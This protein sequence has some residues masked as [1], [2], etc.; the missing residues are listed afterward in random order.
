MR[1]TLISAA[2]LLC[3]AAQGI[4]QP[5]HDKL[6]F[7]NPYAF[8]LDLSFVHSA[9]ERGQSFYDIDGSQKSPWEIF[10]GHGYNWGCLMICNEPSRLG[11]GL[12]YVIEGAKKLKAHDYHFA[13]DF[14]MADGWSN[15]MT[16]P[17][18]ES[19][20]NMT[21]KERGDEKP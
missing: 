17:T 10:R 16:Q 11:Q 15:P 3:A 14:M 2:I 20:K 12:N 9:E 5:S 7:D 21:H 18:P 8:G 6:P 13:L 1:K 19:F 4:A